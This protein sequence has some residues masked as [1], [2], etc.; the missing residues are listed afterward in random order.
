MTGALDGDSLYTGTNAGLA[1]SL[2]LAT[3]RENWRVKYAPLA[4]V[5]AW[6]VIASDGVA[7]FA[8]ADKAL[9]A[10]G[11]NI[12]IFALSTK[13]G[14]MKWRRKMDMVLYNFMPSIVE[15]KLLFIDAR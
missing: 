11:G 13:D 8:G 3:G 7:V 15:G 10:F 9:S 5:D 14:S 4:G 6:T 1:V 2:D 12:E